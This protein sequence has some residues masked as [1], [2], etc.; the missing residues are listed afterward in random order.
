MWFV[1][2]GAAHI[3]F[4]YF[5]IALSNRIQDSEQVIGFGEK[6]GRFASIR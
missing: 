5:L 4:G 3:V 2:G 6:L 1:F